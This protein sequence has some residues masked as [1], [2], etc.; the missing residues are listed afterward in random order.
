MQ[1]ESYDLSSNSGLPVAIDVAPRVREF[2]GRFMGAAFTAAAL[3]LLVF[4]F[5][6]YATTEVL[7][8]LMVALVL[9]FIGVALWQGTQPSDVGE[10][11]LDLKNREIHMQPKGS[12]SKSARKTIKFSDFTKLQLDGDTFSF[13]VGEDTPLT[14]LT[15]HDPQANQLLRAALRESG[16]KV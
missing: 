11:E 13:W 15:L 8:K 3:V 7:C 6:M 9:G 16:H 2:A 1:S 10:L 14:S 12:W 4:P 5:G